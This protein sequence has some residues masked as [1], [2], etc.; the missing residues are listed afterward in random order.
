MVGQGELAT[1]SR[2]MMALLALRS[3]FVHIFEERGQN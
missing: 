1:D 2:A 3:C